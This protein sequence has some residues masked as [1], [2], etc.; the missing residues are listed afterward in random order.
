MFPV[1][2]G[3]W[4]G[5]C[6]FMGGWR[7]GRGPQRVPGPPLRLQNHFGGI[8]LSRCYLPS[9]LSGTDKSLYAFL[10]FWVGRMD[11]PQPLSIY[12]TRRS[13]SDLCFPATHLWL[14]L[15]QCEVQQVVAT[16]S[17]SFY[18]AWKMRM[19]L[20]DE[21]RSANLSKLLGCPHCPIPLI[22]QGA[23]FHQQHGQVSLKLG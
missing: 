19:V 12:P 9:D 22:C 16:T 11:Q 18:P 6:W 23:T 4:F 13:M 14:R 1:V 10:L 20:H 8:Q 3:K 17:G 5:T 15:L 7:M 21:L 2:M